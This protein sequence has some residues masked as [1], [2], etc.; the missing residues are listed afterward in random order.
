MQAAYDAGLVVQSKSGGVPQLKRFLDEQRGR[1]LGDVWTDIP[2]LNS[3]AKER[4]G[5]PTQ[6]PEALMRRLIL[7]ATDEGDTVLDPFCG[8]GTTIS[9]AQRLHRNWIGIDITA[10]A[11]DIIIDRLRRDFPEQADAY[12]VEQ[13]PYSVPDALRLAE[14]DKFHFQ[15]W[16]L[17]KLGVKPSDIKPGADR[18]IDGVLYFGD[19]DYGRTKRVVLSVKGGQRVAPRDVR[20]LRGVLDRDGFEIGVLVSAVEPSDAALA[21]MASGVRHY[22]T[23]DGRRFARLQS[24]TVEDIFRGRRVE[25]P[26]AARQRLGVLPGEVIEPIGE[27][28]PLNFDAAP[29]T[30]AQVGKAKPAKA[31]LTAKPES[32]QPTASARKKR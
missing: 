28:L 9:A 22:E 10:R 31:S 12:K 8:C 24:L 4:L 16:A 19:D 5:Y 3:Q 30:I 26:D 7:A 14:E 29:Q 23:R 1:P 15:R 17:E 21:D 13:Y 32:K 11:I 2:P 18:G 20:E 6:K 25:Y 27:T